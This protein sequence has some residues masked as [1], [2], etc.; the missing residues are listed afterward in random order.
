[1]SSD[2]WP[3]R[4]RKPP[5]ILIA[6]ASSSKGKAIISARRDL[7][8]ADKSMPLGQVMEY[9]QLWADVIS[10][11][12]WAHLRRRRPGLCGCRRIY[13]IDGL[14]FCSQNAS[15]VRCT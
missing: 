5:P 9:D 4:R 3:T 8:E 10:I 15:A 11:A 12:R 13:P 1:M 7:G 14:R 2:D 6:G